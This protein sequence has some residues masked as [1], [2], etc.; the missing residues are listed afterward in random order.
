MY[1]KN[2]E[3]SIINQYLANNK[4]QF[5]KEI[6][7]IIKKEKENKE[8]KNMVLAER[9]FISPLYLSQIENGKYNISLLKFISICNSL[10]M[11][12]NELLEPFLVGCKKEEDKFYY[13]LQKDKNISNNLF[14]YIKNNFKC[15]YK[16]FIR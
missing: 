6:G 11:Y 1:F 13:L 3:I 8:L 2:D 14:E 12:P 16:L 7:K 15:D 9:S 10:E 4:N 5:N